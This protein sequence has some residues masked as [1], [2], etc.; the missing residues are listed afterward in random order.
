MAETGVLDPQHRYELLEGEIV[1]VAPQNVPHA[2]A[3]ERLTEVLVLG[4]RGRYSVRGQLP[5][6]ID[7]HNLPEPDFA[8]VARDRTHHPTAPETFLVVEVADSSI[9]LDRQ[10]K[11]RIY[12]QAQ[13]PEYWIVN[14]RKHCIE[15]YRRP[16]GGA[17]G[18]T[19]IVRAGEA[20]SVAAFP[21]VIVHVDAI[22]ANL[23]AGSHE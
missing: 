19:S 3:V 17:Y 6:T 15:V 10:D 9:A 11:Q 23:D 8:L 2:G 14:V 22:F 13:I 16:A 7:I 4:A 21:D 1:D 5:L 18:E 12:A 20:A